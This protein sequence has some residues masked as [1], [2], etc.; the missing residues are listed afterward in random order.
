MFIGTNVHKFLLFRI[1]LQKMRSFVFL[2][3]LPDTDKIYIIVSDNAPK[4]SSARFKT[5]L[6]NHG[7]KHMLSAPYHSSTNN[8]QVKR[9]VQILRHELKVYL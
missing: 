3:F 4:F 5:F 6:N 2:H 1:Q 8:G 9:Y 7:I